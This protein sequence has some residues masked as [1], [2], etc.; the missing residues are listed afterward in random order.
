MIISE[1]YIKAKGGL[2]FKPP[3][4]FFSKTINIESDSSQFLLLLQIIKKP[5]IIE[6]TC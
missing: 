1:I 6:F 5:W 4:A 3:F 2:N